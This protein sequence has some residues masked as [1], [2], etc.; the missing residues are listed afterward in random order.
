MENQNTQNNQISAKE[1]DFRNIVLTFLG[2]F[3][4]LA[5]VSGATF[6]YYAFSATNNTTITGAGAT[7]ELTLAITKVS[8]TTSSTLVPQTTSGLKTAVTSGCIDTNSN[9]VCQVYSITVTNKSTA[10]ATIGASLAFT[11]GTSSKYTNLKWAT[12][13]DNPTSNTAATLG[14]T[15]S[16]T[17]TAT[18]NSIGTAT[19]AQN[20]ST[21]FYVVIWIN[22]TGAAQNSTDYGTYTGTVTVTDSSGKGLT[23][24]F[25]T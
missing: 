17:T 12:V 11:Y 21:T 5:A 4:V 15:T 10:T 24:T 7:A 9:I 8:P 16:A 20:A 25:T 1:H 13:S 22:E 2:L 3:I 19:L 18:S 23:S 6:A 14:T